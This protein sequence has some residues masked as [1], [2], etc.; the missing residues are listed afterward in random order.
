MIASMSSV[1]AIDYPMIIGKN[2][3]DSELL[4]LKNPT[5]AVVNLNEK[6]N[7]TVSTSNIDKVNWDF[8]DKTPIIKTTTKKQVSSVMHTFKKVG[9][10]KVNIYYKGTSDNINL[11]NTEE[12]ITVKV[13]KKPDLILKE[14]K[15][16][17]NGKDVV[18][19]AAIVKNKGAASSKACYIEIG[20]KDKRL[21][22]YTKSAR[23]SVLKPGKST[24]VIIKFQIPYKYRNYVKYAKVDSTN[25]ISES[26]KTNNNKTFK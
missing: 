20:Y 8:G 4:P 12:F 9:N 5:Y 21:N 13:V 14:V 17:R 11:E 26:I 7:F 15:Y 10:Y 23:I 16:A 2:V 18:G 24:S 22:K 25:R 1:S 19:L 6:V 3:Y